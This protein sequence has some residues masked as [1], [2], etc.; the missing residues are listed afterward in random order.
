MILTD[1]GER[2]IVAVADRMRSTVR[3]SR[4]KWW[5]DEIGLTASFGG[6]TV[7]TGDTLNTIVER[8]EQALG[9]SIKSGGNQT[10]IVP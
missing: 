2:E 3:A 4:L 10:T 5:G 7:R 6:T 8:A 1:C 9:A